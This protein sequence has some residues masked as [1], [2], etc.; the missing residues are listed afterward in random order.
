MSLFGKKPNPTRTRG[1]SVVARA[2][3]GTAVAAMCI[4][5]LT[6][7]AGAA[8]LAR[9]T[10]PSP[11]ATAPPPASAT[12]DNAAQNPQAVDT[13]DTSPGLLRPLT[14]FQTQKACGVAAAGHARCFALV[15]HPQE[16]VANGNLTLPNGYGP[17]DLRSAYGLPSNLGTGNTVAIVDAFDDPSAAADLAQY[18]S[19]YGLPACNAGCFTKYNQA[20]ATSPMPAADSGWAEE[21]SLDVDMASA[22]CPRCHIALVESNSSS[23]SD[24]AAATNTAASIP[25]VV[26]ISNSYGSSG[27]FSSET[28]FDSSYNHPGILVTASSGDSGFGV[29]YPAA[30]SVLTAVGGTSLVKNS[31]ARGWGETAWS[32]AGSG[33]SAF[34]SKPAWQHDG[35]CGRRTVADVS[36]VADPATPVAVYDTFNSGGWGLL[37]GTSVSSPV[38][39]SIS[40]LSTGDFRVN[41]AQ[42]FYRMQT[43]AGIND[44]TSGSNGSCGG[45]Y[46]CTAG[47]GVDGPTGVGS[48]YTVPH[49]SYGYL[50]ASSPTA[51]S[52]TPAATWSFN[53]YGRPN[54]VTR[55]GPGN[56]LVRFNGLA[57]G[58]TVNVTAYGADNNCKVVYWYHSGAAEFV[59]VA[60]FNSAGVATDSYYDV[61]FVNP[62]GRVG[63]R[64]FA[65]D[66]LAYVWA[67]SPTTPSYTAPAFYQYNNFNLANTITR[68]GT[69]NYTITFPEVAPVSATNQGAVKVTA[70]GGGTAQCQSNGWFRPSSS[71]FDESVSVF[72]TT[73]SGAAVDSQFTA[74][75]SADLP[76]TG[77]YSANAY[78]WANAPSTASYNPLATWSYNSSGGA[79]LVT[80]N[81]TGNYTV[82]LPGMTITGGDVQVTSYGS[83]GSRCYTTGWGSGSAGTT[84]GVQCVTASGGAVD[85]YY[86]LQYFR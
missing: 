69:G 59:R 55:S 56:Y 49:D 21:I 40:A 36:A 20:G 85:H 11:K 45:S 32:G 58:G 70:Y 4:A 38:V 67:S 51:A 76:L 18:R 28:S 64:N 6:T 24:L 39:A 62:A 17:A 16:L 74:T 71:N 54:S 26:A 75:Y 77:Q 61:S 68:N 63:A 84:I 30:S 9:D 72:C 34:E 42:G 3:G 1:R 60:C 19:T 53:S 79:N 43:G 29:S 81:A 78:L 80:R 2:L 52:Y 35:G 73:P 14:K 8:G 83:D 7:G 12:A 10:S 41:G 44:V 31:T 22:I 13:T 47:F 5:T 23:M 33:C 37:G 82:T 65:N 46:L 66:S 25:G 50:W 86:N 27:E 15:V 57:D 48:P